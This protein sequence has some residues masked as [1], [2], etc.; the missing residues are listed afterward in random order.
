[1]KVAWHV[2]PGTRAAKIPSVGYGMI[3]WRGGPLLSSGEKPSCPTRTVPYGTVLGISTY[4]GTTCQATF[5][6]SLRDICRLS[7]SLQSALLV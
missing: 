5:F 1:M 7:F 3:G 2:V 6:Q 4:P